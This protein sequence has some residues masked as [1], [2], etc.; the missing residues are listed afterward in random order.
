MFKRAKRKKKRKTKA[1]KEES[2]LRRKW[3]MDVKRLNGYICCIS[4]ITERSCLIAHHLN[5]YH[6]HPEERFNLD[7]GV[8]IEKTL[9]KKFHKIYGYKSTTKEQFAEFLLQE[10][11]L[12]AKGK[13]PFAKAGDAKKANDKGAGKPKTGKNPMKGK[14]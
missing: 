10:K 11:Q 7:N 9:H 3:G 13:N 14:K 4:G 6:T 2:V 5:S 1:E 8:V 12:M